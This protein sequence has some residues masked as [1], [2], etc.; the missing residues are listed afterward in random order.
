MFFICPTFVKY[1]IREL[2]N[3]HVHIDMK[4]A[5][6]NKDQFALFTVIISAVFGLPADLVTH[7]S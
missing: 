4:V 6:S 1:N 5:Q 3:L 2:K 7:E